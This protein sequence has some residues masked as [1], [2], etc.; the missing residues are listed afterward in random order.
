[1][2]NISIV[3]NSERAGVCLR[4]THTVSATNAASSRIYGSTATMRKKIMPDCHPVL[5]FVQLKTPLT[6]S[7]NIRANSPARR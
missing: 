4:A 5:F 6:V 3:T 2:V 7:V 1:V